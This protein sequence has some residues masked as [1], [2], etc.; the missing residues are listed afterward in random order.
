MFQED[1][2]SECLSSLST[3]PRHLEDRRECADQVSS[4]QGSKYQCYLDWK[5][6]CSLEETVQSPFYFKLPSKCRWEVPLYV[7]HI[8]LVFC[9]SHCSTTTSGTREE[10]RTEM[11]RCPTPARE[12]CGT[13]VATGN[14]AANSLPAQE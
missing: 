13:S 6:C 10:L 12:D 1:D 2:Q 14:R 7:Q 3:V 11:E 9:L 5:R 8:T 4:F